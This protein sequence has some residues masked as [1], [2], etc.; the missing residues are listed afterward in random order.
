MRN[1][2]LVLVLKSDLKKDQKEKLFSDVKAWV[3]E[4]KNDKMESLGEKKFAYPIKSARKGE[5]VVMSFDTE[6][7]D[8]DLNKKLLIRDEI[9]RHLLVRTN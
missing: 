8:N 4:T 6:K 1:Y 5:Y 7:V 2:Q 9:L 3:G